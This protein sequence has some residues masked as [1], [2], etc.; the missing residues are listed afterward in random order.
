MKNQIKKTSTLLLCAAAISSQ[1]FAT[2]SDSIEYLSSDYNL[3]VNQLIILK[4]NFIST[5]IIDCKVLSERNS[6]N[7]L[8]LAG[9]KNNTIVNDVIIPETGVATLVVRAGDHMHFKFDH[10]AKLGITNKNVN[11]VSLNCN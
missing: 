9:I 8:I 7:L 2:Q 6:G 10:R 5:R 4:G 11:L 1:S 3:P